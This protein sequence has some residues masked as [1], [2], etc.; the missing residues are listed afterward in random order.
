[1]RFG[2]R[3]LRCYEGEGSF[4]L[5]LYLH[6]KV[7]IWEYIGVTMSLVKL[8]VCVNNFMEQTSTASDRTQQNVVTRD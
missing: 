2:D 8:L 4:A 1:M 7:R 5:Q 6:C 3:S